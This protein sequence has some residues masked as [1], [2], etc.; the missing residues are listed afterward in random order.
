M[1]FSLITLGVTAGPT[2]EHAGEGKTQTPPSAICL[3][4]AVLRGSLG[5]FTELPDSSTSTHSPWTG[6]LG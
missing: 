1:D 5:K 3:L 6:S 4:Q 2:S